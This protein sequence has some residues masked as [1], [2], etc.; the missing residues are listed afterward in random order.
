MTTEYPEKNERQ[1]T[2]ASVFREVHGGEVRKTT[3][4]LGEGWTGGGNL[5]FGG[6]GRIQEV[7]GRGASGD[8]GYGSTVF[9]GRKI[10]EDRQRRAEPGD[11]ASGGER[12]RSLRRVRSL[13]GAKDFGR[14]LHEAS[15]NSQ[16]GGKNGTSGASRGIVTNS[17]KKKAAWAATGAEGRENTKERASWPKR[18]APKSLI[19][20]RERSLT[21]EVVAAYKGKSF[22]VV[23]GSGQGSVQS[24]SQRQG[25]PQSIRGQESAGQKELP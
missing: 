24:L 2:G 4:K 14:A 20:K 10:V 21:R 13:K 19:K 25:K 9:S 3:L 23:E 18:A 7:F 15:L 6:V 11:E 16:K 17:K 12:C 8:Q 22:V 1:G 5:G